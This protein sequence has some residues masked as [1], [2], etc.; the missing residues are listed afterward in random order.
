MWWFIVL[1]V[2]VAV[3]LGVTGSRERGADGMRCRRCSARLPAFR[4]PDSFR[5]LVLGGWT[6]PRCGGRLDSRGQPIGVNRGRST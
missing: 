1:V 4:L 5:Q 6:C 2:V 3:I